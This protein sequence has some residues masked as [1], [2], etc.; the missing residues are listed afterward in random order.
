MPKYGEEQDAKNYDAITR[1]CVPSPASQGGDDGKTWGGAAGGGT[2][3]HC[4]TCV[5]LL[6]HFWD[7]HTVL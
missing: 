1:Q 2:C 7:P 3:T 6:L 5:V 4:C